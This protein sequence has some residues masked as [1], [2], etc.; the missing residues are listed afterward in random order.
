MNEKPLKYAENG[1]RL[2][3]AL[4]SRECSAADLARRTGIH[5]SSISQYLA[6]THRPNFEKAKIMAEVLG[7]SDA[8]LMCYAPEEVPPLPPNPLTDEERA[9]IARFRT[10]DA[11]GRDI[12]ETVISRETI[13]TRKA[14]ISL[15]TELKAAH[16]RAGATQEERA[17]DDAIMEG[18]NF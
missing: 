16:E 2:K 11:R 8:W 18:E 7:V 4:E 3:Q 15:Q 13:L 12:V 5:P 14:E 1:R 10:L 9:L 6:G 17:H